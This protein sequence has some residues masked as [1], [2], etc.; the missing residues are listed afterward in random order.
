[1]DFIKRFAPGN[2]IDEE[3]GER[4]RKIIERVLEV[5]GT[6][7]LVSFKEVLVEG[8]KEKR[9][10]EATR[11]VRKAKRERAAAKP[12]RPRNGEKPEGKE[13][14]KTSCKSQNYWK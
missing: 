10:K 13:E 7:Y 3:K 5:F 4:I 6:N 2:P 1:M 8:V 14:K 12:R 9:E 11:A